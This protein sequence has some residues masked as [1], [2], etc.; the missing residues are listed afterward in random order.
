MT[1]PLEG[2][3]NLAHDALAGVLTPQAYEDTVVI[4]EGTDLSEGIVVRD[5]GSL[6]ADANLLAGHF[7]SATENVTGTPGGSGLVVGLGFDPAGGKDFSASNFGENGV[8]W[9]GYIGYDTVANSSLQ[10]PTAAP[11]PANLYAFVAPSE[12][13]DDTPTTA[14]ITLVLRTAFV[15]F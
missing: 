8:L 11:L 15:I 5:L 9:T 7:I 13:G 1:D 14:E 4:P 3:P 6:A 2:L 10:E 12:P